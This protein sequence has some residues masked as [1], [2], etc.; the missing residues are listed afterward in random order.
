MFPGIHGSKWLDN[1]P[2]LVAFLFLS[3]FF[4]FLMW[5]RFLHLQ[6]KPI[7][8]EIL[9]SVN[10][11]METK[12]KTPALHPHSIKLLK[13]ISHPFFPSE[14]PELLE[15]PYV[16]NFGLVFALLFLFSPGPCFLLHDSSLYRVQIWV[17]I[18]TRQQEQQESL[19][20]LLTLTKYYL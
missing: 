9:A 14:T 18:H 6:N 10:M 7:S 4:T 2:L 11:E 5:I 8:L 20:S 15:K 16:A 1:H 13:S 17:Y 3:Y 19:L 12:N